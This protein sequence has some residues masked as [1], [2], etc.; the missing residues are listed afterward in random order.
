V[1]PLLMS[2]FAPQ[3]QRFIKDWMHYSP[4]IEIQKV[5]I[6]TLIINGDQDLQVKVGEA[7]SLHQACKNCEL[8]IVPKMNHVLKTVD[9]AQNNRESYYDPDYPLS[10]ELVAKLSAFIKLHQ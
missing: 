1:D 7:K 4:L 5:T 10:S 9:N 3:N 6:P 8:A 2:I